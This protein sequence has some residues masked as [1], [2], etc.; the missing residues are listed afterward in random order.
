[1]SAKARAVRLLSAGLAEDEVVSVA[2]DGEAAKWAGK[3]A[4]LVV[5]GILV[6]QGRLDRDHVHLAGL[7]G[8][9]G[10]GCGDAAQELW[11]RGQGR[12]CRWS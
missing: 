9:P 2:A 10:V 12:G 5:T 11:D 1:M 8:G 4:E 7:V 6:Q 3:D